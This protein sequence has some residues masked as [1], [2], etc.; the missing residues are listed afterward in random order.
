MPRP[1]KTRAERAADIVAAA[2]A[3]PALVAR[4]QDTEREHGATDPRTIRA[5]ENVEVNGATVHRQ[6]RPLAGKSKGG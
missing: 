4:A 6:S 1:A 2:S 5:W 3:L